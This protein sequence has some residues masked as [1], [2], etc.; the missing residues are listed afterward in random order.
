MSY[1]KHSVLLAVALFLTVGS[2][3]SFY[4]YYSQKDFLVTVYA[5]CDA[6]VESCFIGTYECEESEEGMCSYDYKILT[7][8]EQILLGCEA[9]EGECALERCEENMHA[10]EVTLCNTTIT[11]ESAT[12]NVCNNSTE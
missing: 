10:C 5:P 12:E 7:M 8:N 4:K 6:S 11:E 2:L 3:A 9:D 1:L